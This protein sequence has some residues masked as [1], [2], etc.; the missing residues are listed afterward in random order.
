VRHGFDPAS[1]V[2]GLAITALGVLLLLDQLD[3]L[4]LSFA[5]AAPAVLAT[6]GASLLALGL[7]RRD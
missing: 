7:S 5:Y 6:A 4:D 1:F 3:V 2:A